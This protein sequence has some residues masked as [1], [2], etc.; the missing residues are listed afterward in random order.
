MEQTNLDP[1]VRQLVPLLADLFSIDAVYRHFD[2]VAFSLSCRYDRARSV[3]AIKD[4]LRTAGYRFTVSETSDGPVLLTVDP[5]RRFRIPPLN[6]ALFVLTIL[7]IYLVPVYGNSGGDWELMKQNLRAGMG[8]QFVAAMI[9]I[10]LVH[11]MGHYVA[12]RRRGIVTTWPYFIPAPNL[13]GTFGAVI[14]SKSPFWNRR[15][16]L[17]VGA[18][19]PIAGWIV[20]VAWLIYGLPHSVLVPIT[21]AGMTQ[22]GDSMIMTV[23][24]KI[25]LGSPPP[26][27]DYALN[28]AA[29]AGWA[30]LL[31]TALNM[32]P[33]GQL[34]GGHVLYGLL[35]K[36]QKYFGWGAA[37]ALLGLG[38]QSPMWWL[39]GGLGILMGV[40]H[41]PTIM[42][43]RP[44]TQSAAVMGV[45]AL[46]ILVLS[47]A[48]VPIRV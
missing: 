9:S 29:F 37:V 13:L 20:A 24:Q 10:L 11:E 5:Q 42:D 27:Y 17:E 19:G 25:M 26:G 41:P 38:F 45:I 15:D 7:S 39:M 23:L 3:K 21:G 32:L 2:Q 36:R 16:L 22:I 34:D 48:P 6:I 14:A 28:E 1:S 43:D 44:P 33:I 46:I 40:A 8:L 35:Q 18:A 30:G 4:R 47:F 31:V 12:S